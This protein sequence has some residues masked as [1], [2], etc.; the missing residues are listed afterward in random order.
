MRVTDK[1]NF[2]DN[3]SKKTI[4]LFLLYTMLVIHLLILFS[5]FFV[6]N[7]IRKV[8]LFYFLLLIKKVSLSIFS[9]DNVHYYTTEMSTI[10]KFQDSNMHKK[11]IHK[12][13]KLRINSLTKSIIISS[14][15][16]FTKK[17]SR[18]RRRRS[19]STSISS[20]RIQKSR[21]STRKNFVPE[22]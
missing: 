7:K 22:A 14:K 21:C 5:H 4:F 12:L 18:R 2:Y 15:Q 20:Q 17:T 19:T 1:K 6:F 16:N 10:Q 9:I 3:L 13:K 8:N 11:C